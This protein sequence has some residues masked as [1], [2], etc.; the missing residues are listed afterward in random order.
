MPRGVIKLDNIIYVIDY[1]K[2]RL[3]CVDLQNNKTKVITVGK[4]P[5]AM[6]LY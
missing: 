5:N 2:G 3:I 6:T 4:E 1:L